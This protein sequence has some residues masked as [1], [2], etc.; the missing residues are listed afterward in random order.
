MLLW[1]GGVNLAPVLFTLYFG[2]DLIR[3]WVMLMIVIMLMMMPIMRRV[4]LKIKIT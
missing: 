2:R 3:N 1:K 4:I